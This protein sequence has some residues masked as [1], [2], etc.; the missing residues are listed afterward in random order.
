MKHDRMIHPVIVVADMRRIAVQGDPK[1]LI[2]LSRLSL[3]AL[4]GESSLDT[5]IGRPDVDAGAFGVQ[6]AATD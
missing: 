3:P 1:Y 6:H 5:G 2:C 4:A